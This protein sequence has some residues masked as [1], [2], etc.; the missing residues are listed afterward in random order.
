MDVQEA[1]RLLERL[2][3]EREALVGSYVEIIDDLEGT[4]IPDDPLELYR[5]L[6]GITARLADY[7]QLESE[8]NAKL[9]ELVGETI[10]ALVKAT[11]AGEPVGG[12]RSAEPVDARLSAALDA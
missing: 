4:P 1:L 8:Q 12:F 5:W 3:R 7:E 6:Y 2:R 10:A 9:M 11:S